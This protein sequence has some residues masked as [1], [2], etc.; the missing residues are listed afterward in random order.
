MQTHKYNL[1]IIG[2][3]G[4]L[5]LI[6]K[7]A[8]VKWL[9]WPKFDSSFVFGSLLDENKGGEFSVTPVSENFSTNQY[10]IE[11]TNVLCTEFE[12]GGDKFRVTDFAP[13]FFQYERYY[14]PLMMVR[15]IEPLSGTPLVKVACEPMGEYGTIKPETFMGSNHIKYV[16]LEQQIR[17]TSNIPL[18]YIM[19]NDFFVLNEPK[20]LIITYGI[21][22]EAPLIDTAE[23]FL[24]KT[25]KYWRDW[26][27]TTS[28]GRFYQDRI[29]R[30]ALVLKIHQFE[31][32]GAIIAAATSSLP[33]SP[34]STRNW[35]YRYCWMRDT[36]YILTAFNNIGHFE[37]MKNYFNYIEN[38]SKIEED[39]FQPLYKI[40]GPKKIEEKIIDLEGYL[41]N[42]PVRIGNDAY[43]HIQ[44]DVYGQVL[45]SLLPL[46]ND[47]RFIT[48]EKVFS[49]RLVEHCL[50]KIEDTM[51]EPDAGLWEFRNKAQLHCYT[52]MFHWAGSAAAY[53]IAGFFKD[54]KMAKRAL[55]LKKEAANRIEACYDKKNKVFTQAVGTKNLDASCL[56]LITMGY[57]KPESEIAKIHLEHLEKELRTTDGLFFRY[58]HKDD[59]GTPES[60]FLICAYWYIEALAC[61]GRVDEAIEIFE[62]LNKYTNHLGLLSEDVHAE[63]GSQWGNFPQAYSH[64]GQV[65]A[66]YRIEKKLDLPNFY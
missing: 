40:H 51:N 49:P 8:Q 43:T 30:S 19:D 2:N 37:E 38:V 56:Q 31:D 5:A 6:D 24:R 7:K 20:Y 12:S 60:T 62:N 59:F 9:C 46:Y 64:V 35:D 33:E 50:Q 54:E 39:R 15:K 53:Q 47:R 48:S 41:G 25:V 22:L 21:P 32:T 58:K 65:N 18:N 57:L 10:Y 55:A 63:T 4:Y 11:N 28:I 44:N 14:K 3:C 23:D 52:F 34:N 27:T 16:G 29:I 61:V 1:G 13:R 26:V 45:V 17:L 66:A 36:Y 42:K